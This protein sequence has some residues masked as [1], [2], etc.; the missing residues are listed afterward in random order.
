MV[1]LPFPGRIP[2]EMISLAPKVA[3]VAEFRLKPLKATVLLTLK[4][5]E[6]LRVP[7]A[8]AL[9]IWRS[10]A[11]VFP[12]PPPANIPKDFAPQVFH[13]PSPDIF[14]HRFPHG[15]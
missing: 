7:A 3:P 2:T 11:C 15:R 10:A 13:F 1:L 4:R 5:T 8:F 9:R 6:I 14:R 12:A